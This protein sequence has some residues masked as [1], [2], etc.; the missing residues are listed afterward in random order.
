[1]PEPLHAVAVV[2]NQAATERAHRAGQDA[3]WVYLAEVLGHLRL[4]YR[5]IS[6]SAAAAPPDDVFVLVFATTPDGPADGLEQWVRD[7]GVLIL[8]GDPGPLAALAGVAAGE[9]VADGH[10]VLSET[11]VWSSRPP[12][13]LH[14][15]GGH[16][17]IGQ[18][19]EVLARWQD[20]DAAAATLRRL[21]AGVVLTYGVDLWQTIV[22]VQQ[23]YAVTADGAPAADGTAPIDDGILKCEDGMVLSF[24]RDRAM[25]PGEPDLLPTY[26]HTYPPPS[27]VPMFDQPQADWWCS[28]FAQSL[29]WGI[30][31]AGAAVPWLWYWPAGVDAV[32]HMSH[33]SDQNVEE[34]GQ[35]AIDA[36]AEADVQVT[37]CHVFP[38]GYSPELYTAITAA[39]HEN[40]L[41]YNAMGDADLALWGWPQMRA[42]Y[43]WAQAVTGTEQIVSNKNHYTRWEGW[44]EFYTWC[45]RLGI[46]IDE[47]RG[48]SKQGDVGFTFGASHVSF[49]LAPVA[50]GNRLYDVLNLPLH[51]Q[52]LAWAGHASVRDVIL[53]G[54]QSVHGVAHFLF[55]GPHLHHRP[56]TRAACIELAAEAR[57]RGMP[58]WTATRI[59][60]WERS[61]RGV[62]LSVE[63]HPDGLAVRAEAV[64]PVPGAAVLLAVPSTTAP[65]VKEGEGSAQAVV[66][67]GRTFVELTADIVAGDNRW[68][69]TP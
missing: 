18:E 61:R 28:L 27:A 22:R 54:A 45:E 63:P 17:L 68:V 55:H 29:W 13:A 57:R 20:D 62:V 33:D 1:M 30:A 23:G 67:L 31:Q 6:P 12:V 16:R 25:P 8:V 11:P 64:E 10:V 49:P 15:V 53:D 36:F 60:S 32:A 50:E 5:S 24:E 52:D 2:D 34:H 42:Q 35:A 9:T 3:W 65:V 48:P 19:V 37:W 4:P 51:T 7:G 41:H 66:R 14:A 21:G 56:P 38:G 69:I 46:Q 26:E 59:N 58:W 40:A 43:A 39:G 44:T 47:S